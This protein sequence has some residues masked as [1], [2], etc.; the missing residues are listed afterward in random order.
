MKLNCTLEFSESGK[1]CWIRFDAT[2]AAARVENNNNQPITI[3]EFLV[4]GPLDRIAKL[5][6][7]AVAP[8]PI[9]KEGQ[10]L[11]KAFRGEIFGLAGYE[12]LNKTDERI[13]ER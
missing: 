1:I 6:V 7:G 12:F 8:T 3:A 11:P 10:I 9:Q 2:R 5:A 13:E 4:H